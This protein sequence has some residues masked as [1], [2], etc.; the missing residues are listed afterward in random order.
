MSR[1]NTERVAG[2]WDRRAGKAPEGGDGALSVLDEI[3]RNV[4]W[5]EIQYVDGSTGG[6]LWPARRG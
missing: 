2:R 1:S 4:D 3:R 6:F 5:Q